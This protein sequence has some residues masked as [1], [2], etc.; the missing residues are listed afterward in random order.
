MMN[1][2]LCSHPHH[3]IETF[4]LPSSI[5]LLQQLFGCSMLWG[6]SNPLAFLL[7][8]VLGKPYRLSSFSNTESGCELLLFTMW[9]ALS[10]QLPVP[11]LWSYA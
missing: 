6:G 4:A 5:S 7:D 10:L 9:A 1:A 11:D 3:P 2:S 8:S